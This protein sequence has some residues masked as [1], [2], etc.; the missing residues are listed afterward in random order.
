[1]DQFQ[2]QIIWSTCRIR[3][4]AHWFRT[5]LNY[6]K[7]KQLS[8][9]QIR[10]FNRPKCRQNKNYKPKMRI[11][12]MQNNGSS[13]NLEIQVQKP[14]NSINIHR[15]K[16]N[17]IQK[18]QIQQNTEG[19][20]PESHNSTNTHPPQNGNQYPSTQTQKITQNNES[21]P[22]KTTQTHRKY[23]EHPQIKPTR[24]QNEEKNMKTKNTE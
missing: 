20:K 24:K 9:R 3:R 6:Y 17:P 1:M 7:G 14:M 4:S 19:P 11:T 13:S 12:A 5:G 22:P 16:W 21:P 10:Q 2:I 23:I 18:W 15:H 8:T